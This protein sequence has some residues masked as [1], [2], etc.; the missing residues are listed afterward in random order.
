MGLFQKKIINFFP[1]PFGLDLSDLSVKGV[2]IEEEGGKHVFRS[3]A[4]V[5]FPNGAVIDGE[6]RDEEVVVAAIRKLSL[7]GRPGKITTKKVV[8]SLPET[9][10]FLRIITLPRMPESEVEEAIKWE[11]E[12]NIPLTLDQ[13][14]YDWQVLPEDLFHDLEQAKTFVLVVAVARSGVDT[15]YA[16]A[17]R[18]GLEV[19]GMETEAVAQARSLLSSTEN[20]GKTTLIVDIGDRR[21]SFFICLGNIPCFTSSVPLSSQAITDAISKEMRIPFEE[22]EKI[23]L[24][25]GIGSFVDENPVFHAARPILDNLVAEMGRS[26]EFYLGNLRYSNTIDSIVLCG[27]GANMKGLIPYLTWK[28]GQ[29]VE[30]GD[31]WV[32]VKMG[33]NLPPIDRNRSVQY[34][35]AIG[36]AIPNIEEYEYLA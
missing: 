3:Y 11:I 27:G 8:C 18:A 15:F 7:E 32:N 1:R 2:W 9:K 10:A 4:S 14:Y 36:L 22:A 6:I 31:P 19:V 29:T 5:S 17:Q 28:M 24:S 30:L 23:K 21:T 16:V 12:A 20:I 34:S 26:M 33:D 25:Q 35:T 13:V